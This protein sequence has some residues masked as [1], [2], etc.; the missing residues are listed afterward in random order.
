MRRTLSL[1][2]VCSLLACGSH[3]ENKTE[4]KSEAPL[5]EKKALFSQMEAPKASIDALKTAYEGV[6]DTAVMVFRFKDPNKAVSAAQKFITE[7]IPAADVANMVQEANE[8][9][10][11]NPLEAGSLSKASGIDLSK[12]F[13]FFLD[14]ALSFKD[15]KFDSY[16]KALVADTDVPI[17]FKLSLSDKTAFV[18]NA[19]KFLATQ[20]LHPRVVETESKGYSLSYVYQQKSEY[21]EQEVLYAA[22]AIK[23][24]KATILLSPDGIY[25]QPNELGNFEEEYKKSLEAYLDKPVT[26]LITETEFF[27]AM[28]AKADP[29][30]DAFFFLDA[31]TIGKLIHEEIQTDPKKITNKAVAEK[32]LASFTGMASSFHTTESGL[33]GNLVAKLIAP[34][35]P[36]MRS[37]TPTKDAPPYG[38]IFPENTSIFARYSLNLLG[39]KDL[40]MAFIPEDDKQTVTQQIE[41]ASG[42]FG[43]YTSLK[44]EDDVLGAFTGHMAYALD[45]SSVTPGTSPAAMIPKMS[46]ILQL[47]NE[48]AGDKILA[49]ILDLPKKLGA[50]SGP[51]IKTEEVFG[52]KLYS[53]SEGPIEVAWG[54]C[55][56]LMVIGLGISSV[57]EIYQ[58][59]KTPGVSFTDKSGSDLAKKM[60]VAKSGG[61]I[62]L[63]FAAF[64]PLIT[65]AI[66]ASGDP[67]AKE[68]ALKLFSK[69]GPIVS[70]SDYDAETQQYFSVM[71]MSFK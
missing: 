40:V 11:F 49:A 48:V 35:D 3:S 9:I 10:G 22:M 71:E 21:E 61:G 17:V 37:M 2:L 16:T 60:V 34:K 63:D 7:F 5:P 43:L 25:L 29:L 44:L 19:K 58:R 31:G 56:D 62:Y 64:S 23:D 42:V 59:I 13:K 20:P 27:Q 39:F 70:Q 47:T 15:A 28:T 57:K 55:S 14:G 18:A 54:R 41:A 53:V 68:F 32:L 8:K 65:P 1:L 38:T 69:L 4:S 50:T 6:P 52:E 45:Y 36:G 30:G 46:F 12:D 26:K 51:T 24:N 33:Q 67:K 66:L